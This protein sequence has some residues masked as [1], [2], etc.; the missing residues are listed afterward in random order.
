MERTKVVIRKLPPSIVNA[1]VRE[2]VDSTSAK[3]N[4]YSFVQGK[5]S[6]K[7]VVHSRCYVN[8]EDPSDIPAFKAAVEAHAFVTD[9]G[10]QFRGCVEYAPFQKV[11]QGKPKRDPREG[12]LEKDPEYLAFV[13]SLDAQPEALPSADAAGSS[14][15]R[16]GQ[17]SGPQVTALMA[18]LQDK[19]SIKKKAPVVVVARPRA[20]AKA[21]RKRG[22]EKAT[23]ARDPTD[24]IRDT[25]R[26][27]TKERKV[28]PDVEESSLDRKPSRRSS[29]SAAAA[30]TKAQGGSAQREGISATEAEAVGTPREASAEDKPVRVRAGF[31]VYQPKPRVSRLSSADEDAHAQPR[32]AAKSSDAAKSGVAAK[33]AKSGVTGGAAR[34][35][36]SDAVKSG[37]ETEVLADEMKVSTGSDKS[38][39]SRR[40][41]TREARQAPK[42][43]PAKPA[44]PG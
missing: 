41:P 22:S 15:Q 34:S 18:Y 10:A 17:E 43:S 16:N 39:R 28:R 7:R 1:D 11:P 19:H 12:T 4:W 32:E 13:E 31:Q 9:R 29:K 30:A 5:T 35:G 38:A 36:A 8:F 23:A 24:Y 3:Y 40:R 6:V 26:I 2:L 42:A 25:P 20:E 14:G 44:E 37:K 27:L 33:A 21:D